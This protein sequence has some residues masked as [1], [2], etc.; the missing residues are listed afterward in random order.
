MIKIKK[1]DQS[2]E[3]KRYHLKTHSRVPI[4]SSANATI[5]LREL[6]VYRLLER[7]NIGPKAYFISNIHT[8]QFGLYIATADGNF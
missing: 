4:H 3:V 8:S 1:K 2:E 5:D 6:Y 7:I